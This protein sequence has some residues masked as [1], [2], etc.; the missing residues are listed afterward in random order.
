MHQD[1]INTCPSIGQLETT[2]I[3]SRRNP[4]NRTTSLYSLVAVSTA[5]QLSSGGG[6]WL[7]NGSYDARPIVLVSF[8]DGG[9]VRIVGGVGGGSGEP[10]G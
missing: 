7:K 1:R 8:G 5:I 10:S 4:G 6:A 3:A 2:H 9:G